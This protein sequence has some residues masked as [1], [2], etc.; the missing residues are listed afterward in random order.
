MADSKLL[1]HPSF[2]SYSVDGAPN[3]TVG[4][5]HVSRAAN[6]VRLLVQEK[7]S[8]DG[9]WVLYVAR[10]LWQHSWATGTCI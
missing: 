2:P 7:G 5:P 4:S 10:A 9:T 3:G 6:H 8:S 1:P